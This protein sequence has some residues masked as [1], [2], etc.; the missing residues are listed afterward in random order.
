MRKAGA[1]TVGQDAASCIVYGMPKVAFELGAVEK[2][3]P[4]GS[5]A[6]ELISLTRSTHQEKTNGVSEEYARVDRR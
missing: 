4:L 2:Q 3:L 5:I 6:N 1:R